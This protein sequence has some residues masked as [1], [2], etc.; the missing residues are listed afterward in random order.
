MINRPL[1]VNLVAAIL[2]II[3]LYNRNLIEKQRRGNLSRIADELQKEVT[4][5]QRIEDEL[6][7]RATRS[8][9]ITNLSHTMTAI[10][11]IDELLHLAVEQISGKFGY[12]NVNL[13][14]VDGEEIVLRATSLPGLR[15]FEG[16]MK[17][18]LGVEG[19]TGWVAGHGE[20][21]WIPD[22]DKDDRFFAK[23]PEM[24]VKSSP[25]PFD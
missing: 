19:V 15:P 21:L 20:P 11:E 24:K 10:L 2:A 13:L 18:R 6:R 25:A 16:K 8:E 14:L 23:V 9:L 1:S 7:I 12:T 5:R 4:E 22:V 17:L 3:G